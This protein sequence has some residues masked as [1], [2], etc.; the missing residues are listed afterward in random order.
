[1]DS[2]LAV[3][4][5]LFTGSGCQRLWFDVINYAWASLDF[6]EVLLAADAVEIRLVKVLLIHNVLSLGFYFLASQKVN[7]ATKE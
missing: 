7:P 6:S 1:M 5:W 2:V 4:E 3:G